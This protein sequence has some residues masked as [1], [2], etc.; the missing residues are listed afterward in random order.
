[1]FLSNS[2]TAALMTPLAKAIMNE[3]KLSKTSQE[4]IIQ[5]TMAAKAIDISI[6]YGSTIGGQATITGT[7]ANLVLK[8]LML[9]KL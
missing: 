6:A 7:G 3:L 4:E 8:G 1:M 5:L 9:G 2:A